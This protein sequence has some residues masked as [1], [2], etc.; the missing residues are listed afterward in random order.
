[1]VF[2]EDNGLKEYY[3]G[4]M[5]LKQGLYRQ[6]EDKLIISAEKGNVEAQLTLGSSY[7]FGKNGFERN[8][9]KAV[10]WYGKAADQNNAGANKTL[11]HMYSDE[12]NPFYNMGVAEIYFKK[13]YDLGN[14]ESAGYLGLIYM[15]DDYK[16]RNYNTAHSYFDIAINRGYPLGYYG[17]GLLAELAKDTETARSFF[18]KAKEYGY[19]ANAV[20]D[21]LIRIMPN[22]IEKGYLTGSTNRIV[23]TVALIILAILLLITIK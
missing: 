21:A 17:K 7:R 22:G 6:A 23:V 20:R 11:G 18:N 12:K 3:E 15:D 9:F 13:A 16:N 10:A 5:F 2:T 14:Y 8:I 4:D 1:M 19:D